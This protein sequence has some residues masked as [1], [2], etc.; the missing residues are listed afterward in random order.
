MGLFRFPV[1]FSS[2][3]ISFVHMC[4]MAPQRASRGTS[5]PLVDHFARRARARGYLARSAFKLLELVEKYQT[6]L[7]SSS[8]LPRVLDLGCAPG[9]WTQVVLER[10]S[11]KGV[12]IGVDLAQTPLE[13][14]HD[15]R[16][17]SVCS[18]MTKTK[19]TLVK[20]VSALNL[21]NN[22]A[23][24]SAL[25]DCVLSDAMAN[26]TGAREVDADRSRELVRAAL[27][28]ALG[29]QHAGR[30]DF[31][32]DDD[33][34]EE[35]DELARHLAQVGSLRAR[36]SV[37]IKLFAGDPKEEK[38]ILQLLRDNFTRAHRVRLSTSRK[39]SRE[40]Y[41]VGLGRRM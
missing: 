30:D 14:I 22:T 23:K 34:E 38:A 3:V 18:D 41:L 33:D 1:L 19:R 39:D 9:S 26:T 36:G 13:R 2:L 5:A 7:P 6:L 20:C 4:A 10:M 40:E 21:N 37:A 32:D 31:G 25:F 35:G 8:G 12:V 17:I 24:P 29:E 16:A 11:P 15:A 27:R 28:L